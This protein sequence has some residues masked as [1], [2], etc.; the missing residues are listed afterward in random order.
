M[1]TFNDKM[2]LKAF[3]NYPILLGRRS[4][5]FVEKVSIQ[6]IALISSVVGFALIKLKLHKTW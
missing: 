5:D 1:I 2:I 4:W 6:N 3:C